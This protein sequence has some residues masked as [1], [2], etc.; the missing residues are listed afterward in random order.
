NLQDTAPTSGSINIPREYINLY[1]TNVDDDL[2]GSREKDK[3]N[4]TKIDYFNDT[5]VIS[6]NKDDIDINDIPIIIEEVDLEGNTQN[7]H[8][9]TVNNFTDTPEMS[10]TEMEKTNLLIN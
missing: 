4:E 9:L 6:N 1:G 2:E 10:H 5:S 8:Q 3:S 7:E